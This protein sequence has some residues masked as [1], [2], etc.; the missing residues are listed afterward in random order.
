MILNLQKFIQAEEPYWQELD[1]LIRSWEINSEKSKNLQS[2]RRLHYLYQRASTGLN[3]ITT[4]SSNQELKQY[5]EKLVARSYAEIHEVRGHRKTF[6]ML[7]WFTRIFPATFRRHV[8]AFYLSVAITCIGAI[9]GSTI[10][11]LDQDAKQTILPFQHL[12]GSPNERV[13][14]EEKISGKHINGHQAAFSAQLMTHNTQVSIFALAL[15]LTFGIGTIIVLFYNGI[16]LGAVCADYIAA[17][18]GTFLTGWLLPHG[19]IEIP[20]ILIAGQAGL[21]LAKALIGHGTKQTRAQRL[22]AISPD[23]TTLISAVGIMLIWAGVIESF[24]SQYHEPVIPYSVKI[25]FGSIEL[26]LLILF[27]SY[28]GRSKVS[29]ANT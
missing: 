27:L 18:Q 6:N 7:K 22:R 10:V 8:R 4:F 20:A 11:L 17:G 3:Q 21:I 19:S 25:I 12:V 24:V 13:A 1:Q 2:A 14:K 15:G 29:H 28:A 16:I 23:L 9:F 26:I 5:L